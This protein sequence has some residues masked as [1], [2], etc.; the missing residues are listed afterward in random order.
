MISLVL[1]IVF[2]ALWAVSY[3]PWIPEPSRASANGGFAF[4]VACI[5]SVV[6]FHGRF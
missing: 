2:L 1:I 4:I 6:V 5:L 3:G